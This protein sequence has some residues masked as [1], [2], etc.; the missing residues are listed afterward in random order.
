M[1][2]WS[3]ATMTK[4]KKTLHVGEN[5]NRDDNGLQEEDDNEIE[6]DERIDFIEKKN[7]Q[8]DFCQI[9]SSRFY[10]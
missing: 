8:N 7:K 9:L 1:K 3:K 6:N 5:Y 10:P 2:Q 4:K